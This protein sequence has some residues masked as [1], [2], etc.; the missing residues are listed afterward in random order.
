MRATVLGLTTSTAAVAMATPVF[1]QAP[2]SPPLLW[3]AWGWG[4][5]SVL[6]LGHGILTALF[7]IVLVLLVVALI[8]RLSGAS[9]WR[10]DWG[11]PRQTAVDI[12]QERFARGEIDKQEYE[13]RRR[14]LTSS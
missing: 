3:H 7:W 13:D 14:T 8:R 5:G 1:A 4:W 11:S 2:F 12:L 6:L 9:S 10:Q